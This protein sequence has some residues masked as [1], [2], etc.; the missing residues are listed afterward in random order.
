MVNTAVS[1]RIRTPESCTYENNRYSFR[2]GEGI[3]HIRLL[4]ETSMRFEYEFSTAVS[5]SGRTVLCHG[6]GRDAI[7]TGI[8]YN[9]KRDDNGWRIHVGSRDR[10]SPTGCDA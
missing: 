9:C 6:S 7:P 5:D 2:G 10:D 4:S 8:V 1:D 3:I